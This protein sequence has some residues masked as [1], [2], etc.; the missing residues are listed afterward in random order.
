MAWGADGR[1]GP[2]LDGQHLNVWGARGGG[3]HGGRS[4]NP[5]PGDDAEGGDF[6][7]GHEPRHDP[8][9]ANPGAHRAADGDLKYLG[10]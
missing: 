1:D 7:G 10:E 2:R 5:G 8:R 4:S 3:S 9:T 6:D